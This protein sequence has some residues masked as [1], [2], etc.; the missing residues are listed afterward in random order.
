MK[1]KAFKL[2]AQLVR[3]NTRIYLFK[4]SKRTNLLLLQFMEMRKEELQEEIKNI[5]HNS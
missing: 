4:K 3:L 5:I 2:F 1:T